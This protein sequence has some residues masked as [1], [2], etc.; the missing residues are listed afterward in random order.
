[1]MSNRC[2]YSVRVFSTY[3]PSII[4]IALYVYGLLNISKFK[5]LDKILNQFK[6][7]LIRN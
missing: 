4:V 1:M 5:D 3:L 7:H 2:P 6:I